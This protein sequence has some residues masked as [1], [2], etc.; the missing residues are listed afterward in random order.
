MVAK[1]EA[2]MMNIRRAIELS[3]SAGRYDNQ[4]SPAP[5]GALLRCPAG[6]TVIID[7]VNVLLDLSSKV[8]KSDPNEAEPN[9]NA[10]NTYL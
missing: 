2:M 9:I 7:S 1:S 10:V 5:S 4:S 3:D 8:L 6:E